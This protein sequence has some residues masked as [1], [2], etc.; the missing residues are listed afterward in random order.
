LALPF[1]EGIAPVVQNGYYGL[2]D[3]QG[4]VISDFQWD[5]AGPC[6]NGMVAVEKDGLWGFIKV[7]PR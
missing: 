2:I 5:Y 3:P 4:N 6:K 1:R 7:P